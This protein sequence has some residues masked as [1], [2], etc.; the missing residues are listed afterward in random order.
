MSARTPPRFSLGAGRKQTLEQTNTQT[1]QGD[2][3]AGNQQDRLTRDGRRH[4]TDPADGGSEHSTD[5][6]QQRTDSD[7]SNLRR[8]ATLLS[9]VI[10]KQATHDTNDNG[11]A[12]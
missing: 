9:L 4:S 8:L 3:Y 10:S 7:G 12:D 5:G 11:E 6:G 1:T 2:T